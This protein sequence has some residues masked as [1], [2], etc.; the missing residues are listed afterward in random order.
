MFY[1]FAF[2]IGFI[3]LMAVIGSFKAPRKNQTK[4]DFIPATSWNKMQIHTRRLI[5][6]ETGAYTTSSIC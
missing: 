4:S 2:K 3:L 5:F 1:Y 6:Q